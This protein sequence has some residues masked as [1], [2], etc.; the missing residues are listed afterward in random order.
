MLLDINFGWISWQD[1]IVW[2]NNLSAVQQIIIVC[3]VIAFAVSVTILVC[4]AIYY[5]IKFI[6]LGIY[7]LL[8]GIFKGLHHILVAIFTTKQ[9][10]IPNNEEKTEEKEVIKKSEV[11]LPRKI[12]VSLENKQP[13]EFNYCPECGMRFTEKMNYHLQLNGMT[14]CVNCGQ[15]FRKDMINQLD[16]QPVSQPLAKPYTF[17]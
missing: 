2:F 13:S 5:L 6:C 9:K 8:K 11:K 15:C 3:L 17:K 4:I 12:E 16:N 1:F 10:E 14:F 7:Y